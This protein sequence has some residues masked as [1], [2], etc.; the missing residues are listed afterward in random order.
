MGNSNEKAISKD[1][2][3]VEIGRKGGSRAKTDLLAGK[4]FVF[5]GTLRTMS[6]EGAHAL[7]RNHGGRVRPAPSKKTSYIVLGGYIS[8]HKL[9]KIKKHGWKTLNEDEFLALVRHHTLD[10]L[11]E[12]RPGNWN[13]LS[14]STG[15]NESEATLPA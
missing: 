5:S 1:E 14:H 4:R 15:I 9:G 13:S 3:L 7:V 2:T 11:P 8:A 10:L 6:R 12:K